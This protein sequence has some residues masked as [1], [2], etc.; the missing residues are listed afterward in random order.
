MQDE[1]EPVDQGQE[2]LFLQLRGGDSIDI[3]Q[4]EAK[5]YVDPGWAG[6]YSVA[7]FHHNEFPLISRLARRKGGGLVEA[8][9]YYEIPAEMNAGHVGSYVIKYHALEENDPTK[10]AEPRERVVNVLDVDEC[11][12]GI[13]S[14]SIH[15]ACVNTNGSYVCE[16]KKGFTGDGF[17]CSDVNECRQGLADC[18]PHADCTNTQGSYICTCKAGYEG[19]G[20]TCVNI[21]E[22]KSPSLNKCDPNADCIDTEGSYECK[23]RDG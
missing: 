1:P 15:S 10:T 16:C 12:L 7:F 14:C 23:C 3:T 17:K 18:D 19:D 5:S 13:H 4:L 8:E 21:D 6:N 22:C 9:V 20:K 11:Q 2:G